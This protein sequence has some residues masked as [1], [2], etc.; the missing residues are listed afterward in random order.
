MGLDPAQ[1]QTQIHDY[2]HGKTSSIPDLATDFGTYYDNAGEKV[3]QNLTSGVQNKASSDLDK[4]FAPNFTTNKVANTLDDPYIA[5]IQA[6]QE[7]QATDYLQN[8]LTR[9][10]ITQGGYDAGYKN[11][12]GQEP[13]VL[14]K[15]N[16]LG[17][18]AL[19]KEK[20]GI[21]DIIN[22]GYTAAGKTKLGQTFNANDYSTQVNSQFND[23]LNNL[24]TT[25]KGGVGSQPLFDTSGLAAIAGG[26]QGAG[27]S[28]VFDPKALAGINEEDQNKKN[29]RTGASTGLDL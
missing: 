12:Q 27:T 21:Q 24:G 11:V 5:E 9:G 1:Y 29:D 22:S 16:E 4:L 13:G 18:G 17:Q 25:I 3:Y 20:G 28:Q 7:K 10:V 15:L 26:A 8:L 6:A 19:E 23:W 14:A 2:V